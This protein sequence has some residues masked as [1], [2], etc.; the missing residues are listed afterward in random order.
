MVLIEFI[1]DI[2]TSRVL[3]PKDP[4][5]RA[6]AR[7]FIEVFSSK[8]IPAWHASAT[9]GESLDNLL[10]GIEA[11]QVLL[12]AKGYAIGEWSIADAAVIPFLARAELAIKNDLGAFDEGDGKK[13]YEILQTDPKFGRFREYL[14]ALKGRK[15]FQETFDTVRYTLHRQKPTH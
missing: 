6:K 3:L 15:S 2:S 5:L 11:I 1:A 10:Q 4:V 9:K 14:A 13:A 7:F 8:F 12:P